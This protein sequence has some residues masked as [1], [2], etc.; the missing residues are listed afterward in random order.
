[1]IKM[2]MN[3]FLCFNSL[4]KIVMEINSLFLY[5]V[6]C[7]FTELYFTLKEIFIFL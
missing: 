3:M 4:K 6:I 1:M 7:I 5:N 2:I